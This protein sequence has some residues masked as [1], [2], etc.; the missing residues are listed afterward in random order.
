MHEIKYSREEMLKA[1]YTVWKSHSIY[2]QSVSYFPSRNIQHF[3]L[4]R[5]EYCNPLLSLIGVYIHS[6]VHVYIRRGSI[7]KN[8]LLKSTELLENNTVSQIWLKALSLVV[9]YKYFL[10]TKILGMF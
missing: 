5:N 9:F 1:A 8:L 2:F 3:L 6:T 7:T 4:H 10:R